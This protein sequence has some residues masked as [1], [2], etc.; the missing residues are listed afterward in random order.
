MRQQKLIK[1]IVSLIS[2][3]LISCVIVFE[4]WFNASRL[5]ETD[6]YN[7]SPKNSTVTE[8]IFKKDIMAI[9]ENYYVQTGTNVYT[10][11]PNNGQTT[12]T[13]PA[14]PGYKKDGV[15]LDFSLSKAYETNKNV[16]KNGCM[17]VEYVI[18]LWEYISKRTV[19]YQIDGI[20]I[21][22]S[23]ANSFFD[24]ESSWGAGSR[25]SITK[26]EFDELVNE[27]NFEKMSD[28]ERTQYIAKLWC[29]RND[30]KRVGTKIQP[31]T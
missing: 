29:E 8:E 20:H 31:W 9:A 12:F 24:N 4:V 1:L 16:L 30:Y 6:L 23:M 17:E 2:I 26:S 7:I 19:P 25:F 11:Y 27:Y 18:A 13:F 3:V 5:N 22:F 28:F 21:N 10:I 15:T 14:E